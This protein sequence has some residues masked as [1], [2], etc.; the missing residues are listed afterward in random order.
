MLHHTG[1]KLT[2]IYALEFGCCCSN[3]LAICLLRVYSAWKNMSVHVQ[4]DSH[5]L[6]VKQVTETLSLKVTAVRV[7]ESRRLRTEQ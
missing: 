7:I 1:V 4:Q 3:H 6:S 2:T 5:T